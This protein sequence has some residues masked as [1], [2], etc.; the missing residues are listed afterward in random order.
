MNLK[1][2]NIDS[3]NDVIF[4]FTALDLMLNVYVSASTLLLFHVSDADYVD[5]DY[6]HILS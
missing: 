4:V 1:F 6:V 5:A 3:L 2:A